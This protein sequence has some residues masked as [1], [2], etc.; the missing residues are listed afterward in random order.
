MD[1]PGGVVVRPLRR[2]FDPTLWPV[3][4]WLVAQ[5]TQPSLAI[6]VEMT[7][8]VTVRSDATVE[9]VVARNAVQERAW[10]FVPIL[11]CPA[12][13]HEPGETEAAIA[14]RWATDEAPWLQGHRAA[15][16][17]EDPLHAR[18]KAAVERLFTLE[19]DGRVDGVSPLE[20]LAVKPADRGEGIVVRLADRTGQGAIRAKLR[21]VMPLASATLCDVRERDL[22]PA[23]F[24]TYETGS[25]VSIAAERSVA[26]VRLIPE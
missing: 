1:Q 3:A 23:E 25:E 12:R 22:E 24:R 5:G 26:S 16:L 20:V 11:A 18:F 15:S 21:I 2:G 8:A 9:V 7:R 14:L 4:S 10:R 17:V 19:D 6:G 13:G